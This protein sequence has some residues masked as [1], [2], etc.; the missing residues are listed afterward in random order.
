MVD[1]IEE[2]IDLAHCIDVMPLS[3]GLKLKRF[4]KNDG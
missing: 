4:Q 3:V 1:I 2:R